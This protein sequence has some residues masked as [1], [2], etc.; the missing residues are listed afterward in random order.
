M[1]AARTRQSITRTAFQASKAQFRR[2]A[3]AAAPKAKPAKKTHPFRKFLFKLGFYTTIAYAGATA[4]AL[5]VDSFQDAFVDY[6]P[7]AEQALDLGTYISN[8]REQI[9]NPENYNFQS[10][11]DVKDKLLA[12][13]KTASIPNSGAQSSK[14]DSS[15]IQASEPVKS[16]STEPAKLQIPLLTLDSDN[17]EIQS[18]V[19]S[20]NEFISSINSSKTSADAG[21][22]VDSVS[23]TVSDLSK[24]YSELASSKKADLEK[25]INDKSAELALQYDEKKVKLTEEFTNNLAAAKAEIEKK[26]NEILKNDLQATKEAILAEAQNV[27][28]KSKNDTIDEFNA[29]VAEKV[30]NERNGKLKNL[31]AAISR[32]EELE[33][34]EIELS[35]TAATYS[36]YKAIK[37][38]VN[39]IQQ[40]LASNEPSADRGTILSKELANLKNLTAPLK[41][42]L[43]DSAVS[44]LP[45]QE[46]LLR[47]G[48]VLTQSQLISRWELLLLEL[49]SVSLLPPNAGLL[50]H[51]SSIFF[52]K[53]LFSKSGAPVKTDNNLTG[54][55]VE[56]VIARVNDYLV[57]NELDSAV[58][59]VSGLKGW[60]R[61]LADD[62]LLES[63]KKLELQF[64]VDVIDTELTVSA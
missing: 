28:L 56:S 47:T 48:G 25:F 16:T 45:S 44:N 34:F 50:G 51:V 59:E 24:K 33:K 26:H 7:L 43:I 12:M 2:Q 15:K 1:Y 22:L 20:I 6:V 8:H 29:V 42:E 35:K 61:K 31:S 52:S 60:A 54:N 38:S 21:K 39:K 40:I 23:N 9:F 10:I 53:F 27:V 11:N 5:K 17:A 46:A 41:N 32:V 57:K 3:T 14:V 58:E 19:K 18:T 49:R 4:V 13:E 62:W 64:L 30:E 63:R 55:D 36:N 37:I